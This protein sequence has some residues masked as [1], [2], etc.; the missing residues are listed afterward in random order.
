VGRHLGAGE[1]HGVIAFGQIALLMARIEAG[2]LLINADFDSS[3]FAFNDE[4]RSTPHELGFGHGCSRISDPPIAP[5]IGRN[6]IVRERQR[7]NL[8]LEDGGSGRRPQG[9]PAGRED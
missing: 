3:R 6:A 2:L 7:R 1:G 8:A 4:H 5:F 9:S